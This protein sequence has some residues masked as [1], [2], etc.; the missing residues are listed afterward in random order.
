MSES[1]LLIGAGGHAASCIEAVESDGRL[2]IRGLIGTEPEVGTEICGYRVIG[3]DDD[4][5]NLIT[6]HDGA[7]VSIG[8]IQ[9]PAPRI[10]SYQLLKSLD[11]PF[12]TVIA[13]SAIVSKH[14]V[15]GEGT[16]VMHRGTVNAAAS[17]GAN[18]II[19]SAALIEH[20][21]NIGNHCH[22]STGAIVNGGASIGDG[23]F[24]GSGAVILQGV[25]VGPN[26][27]VG[28]QV[29]VV[30]DLPADSKVRREA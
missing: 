21:A 25:T 24:V 4:L 14:S 29:L 10:R 11:C 6:E 1:L 19:N 15:I 17:V 30:K 16:I 22:I 9:S 26:S 2:V 18:S 8:Q 13:S 12:P 27:V 20:D 7:L 23:T 28:A 5:P 3:T